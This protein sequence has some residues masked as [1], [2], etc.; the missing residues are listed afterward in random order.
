VAPRRSSACL[1]AVL[2]LLAPASLSACGGGAYAGGGEAQ[3]A[4]SALN[5]G[6]LKGLV[7]QL[8]AEDDEQEHRELAERE[9]ARES[10][11]EREEA[12]EQGQ[13]EEGQKQEGEE[14]AIEEEAHVGASGETAS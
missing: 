9:D 2:A 8:E 4:T 3:P 5:I 11:L 1:L 14:R 12:R 10:P 13:Q 7:G 6:P